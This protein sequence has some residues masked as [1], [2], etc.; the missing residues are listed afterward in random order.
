MDIHLIDLMLGHLFAMSM[1]EKRQ[2]KIDSAKEYKQSCAEEI[3]S[4]AADLSDELGDAMKRRE[5]IPY[6]AEIVDGI[7]LLILY[8]FAKVIKIQ[9]GELTKEQ[10]D[11]LDIFF[12]RFPLSF[13]KTDFIMSATSINAARKQIVKSVGVSAK[14]IGNFWRELFLLVSTV[15]SD[16]DVLYRVIEKYMRMLKRFAALGG[17]SGSALEP[18]CRQFAVDTL[19][20]YANYKK[21]PESAPDLYGAIPPAEHYKRMLDIC[22]ILADK[23]NSEDSA[24][25]VEFIISFSAAGLIYKIVKA[26][27]ADARNHAEL[28]DYAMDICNINAKMNGG[29]IIDSIME[30]DDVGHLIKVMTYPKAEGIWKYIIIM[31]NEAHMKDEITNFMHELA[32]FVMGTGVELLKKYPDSG[33][34]E[35]ARSCII[36]VFSE[37]RSLMEE[38]PDEPQ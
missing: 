12:R 8:S 5:P 24:D 2:R 32:G 31:A 37:G 22:V 14:T 23:S 26:S 11:L 3:T 10:S 7:P 30:H 33:S 35:A 34:L 21:N 25:D 17:I 28:L 9:N 18:V 27:K 38:L 1:D 6:P 19:T 15:N 13:T 36:E 16:E 29:G 4:A 20:H